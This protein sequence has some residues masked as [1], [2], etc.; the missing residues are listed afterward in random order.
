MLGTIG[1]VAG[2]FGVMSGACIANAGVCM[3][4]TRARA[5][6]VVNKEEVVVG[7]KGKRALARLCEERSFWRPER[8]H[9]SG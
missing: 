6:C 2:Y 4:E 5:Q 9:D 1:S 7:C 8:M 3:I